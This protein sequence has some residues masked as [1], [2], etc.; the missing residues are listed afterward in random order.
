MDKAQTATADANNNETS[1]GFLT[2]RGLTVA[3]V[4]ALALAWGFL[5][6]FTVV[7]VSYIGLYALVAVGLA[8]L[9]GVG[10]MTS[11][12]QAAFVGMGAY[13]T[14]WICT[15]PTA[16]QWLG[17]LAGSA[18][19]PW[20]GLALGL[21]LTFALA[22]TLGAVTVKL[23]GH[24]LPLCTIAWGL[25]LYYLF[26]NMEFLGGQTGITGVP[27]LVLFGYSLASPRALGIVIWSA[28]LIGLWL[29][30]NLLDSREGRAIRALK[31]GR[32]MAESMGVDTARHRI[33]L[34]VLAA[35]MAAIS[36]WL[37][38]HMQRFVNPTPF[39]LNIG[40]EYLFMAV[41]GGAGHL[42]GA[43][44][45]AALITLLKEK[46]QDVLPSLLGSSG[47]FEVIVFGLLMLL[48]LQRFADGIWPALERI[49]QRFLRP[50]KACAPRH[51]AEL[52]R[53]VLPPKGTVLLQSQAVTKRF[54]GL[55]AND[56]VTMNVKAG[57]IHAL[58]GPNG[59]GKSTFFNMISGVDD[60]TEGEVRLMDQPMQTKP[61]RAFAALGLGRT[62]QHVRLLGQRSVV[63]N[64]ALGAHLR[65]RR[66]W[67]ASMLRLDRAEEAALQA[68]ARRQIERCGLAAHA[69]AP[70]AS[71]ALGQQRI[72]EIAR[73]LASQ[74]AVLL[75]DEPAAGLRHLEKRALAE[76]L[77]QLRAEG[78]GILVVE[79][80]MEFVMNLAD[81]ITV[82]EFGT[83]I[84]EG[85]PAEVQANPRVLDAYL[86]GVDEPL[87][88]AA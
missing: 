64:V 58:I 37:Y 19:V 41:V 48:V 59:A 44:L 47:N 28:L 21:V 55:V 10:G 78:L 8:M 1:R 79:H 72:V 67:L 75:L 33:K 38:A 9:T 35:L 62:F 63:D 11:F 36:G 86:G 7:V 45:G 5:P 46:L 24:Y 73:A 6:E 56:A 81:R 65:A 3:A 54:G 27:A 77:S 66:G 80:D 23:Q 52:A 71:L 39:N 22:W 26:G 14:A 53:R 61:A 70:A 42:W 68:E 88:A 60:P 87:E 16:A 13:A 51:V 76:L 49:G 50:E 69:D 15:S 17:P 34:F 82:L 20:F 57:E 43:V 83:V 85:K 29:L 2:R 31:S 18:I 25:G 32:L 30:H 40:I 4:L 84:A 12:G 74:P